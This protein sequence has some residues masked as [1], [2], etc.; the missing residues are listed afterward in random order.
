MALRQC[1]SPHLRWGRKILAVAA[2]LLASVGTVAA[3][4]GAILRGRVIGPDGAPIADATV[5]LANGT[6]V[7]T[8]TDGRF[9]IGASGDVRLS[10]RAVGFT[11]LEFSAKGGATE[12]VLL[13]LKRG[14]QTVPELAVSAGNAEDEAAIPGATTVLGATLLQDRAPISIM[15]ALRTVPGLSVA[16]EDPYGINLN[17]GIRGLPPRRSSRTLIMED[18]VPVLLGAY[19]DPSIH[20]VPARELLSRVE[21]RK[22]SSQIA[23]G[24]QTVGG[25]INFVTNAPPTDGSAGSVTVSGGGLAY[26]SGVLSVGSGRNGNGIQFD[27]LFRDGDGV[28]LEQAHQIQQAILKGVIKT[29]ARSSLLLKTSIFD[30]NSNIS[31]TGLTQAEFEANPISLPFT[32][33]GRFNVRRYLGQATHQVQF[34]R[35]KLTTNVYYTDVF[36]ASWRQSGETEERIE[37][38]EYADDFNCQPG[39]TSYTQCGNQGRPRNYT[40]FGVE[41]RLTVGYDLGGAV[42][43]FDAGLRFHYEDVIRR[44]FVGNTPTSRE[45]DAELN[46]DNTIDTRAYSGFVQNQFRFGKVILTPAIRIERVNQTIANRFP[47]EE[48]TL[49]QAYTQYLPGLGFSVLTSDNTTLFAGVH[50]GFAPPRPADVYGVEAGQ[51][52]VLVDPETNWSYE[53]GVRTQPATGVSFEATAFRMDFGNEVIEAPASSGQ[54]F[55]NGGRTTHQGI[56][57]GGNLSLGALSRSRDDLSFNAA[58]TYL[59]TARFNDDDERGVDVAGNRLP[60]AP[61]AL[62]TLGATF[63]HRSGF[64]LGSSLEHV[65]GQFADDENIPLPDPNGQDGALPAYTVVSAFSSFAIPSTRVTLRASVRNLFDST[66]ITQKNE[67][68]YTGVRRFFRAEMRWAF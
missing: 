32:A 35:A 8:N 29:G 64:T 62:V 42:S 44:R 13:T 24:P 43:R 60:Y 56:E 1:R 57:F 7:R 30:E 15:E 66:Y 58:V 31:E 16:D 21:I 48:A 3:Q 50:R 4:A 18:G 49:D 55:I 39:A 34:G 67:G 54:R 40:N 68:I 38:D 41:P 2:L 23:N 25:V 59:P 12:Q 20:Y 53:V 5:R 27:Y 26:K 11:P 6:E 14:A 63:A 65:G 9:A 22:G 47:G 33:D 51:S 37:E 28:R 46:Q 19:G 36:R 10:V 45:D 61:K 52:V 17:V